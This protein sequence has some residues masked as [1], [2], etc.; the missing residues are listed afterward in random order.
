MNRAVLQDS[1]NSLCCRRP[2]H[3]ATSQ[4]SQRLLK[5]P[6]ERPALLDGQS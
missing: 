5:R 2:R 6:Q 4:A 3:V 1:D